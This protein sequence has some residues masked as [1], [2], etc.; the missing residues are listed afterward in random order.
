MCRPVLGPSTTMSLG[1]QE[2]TGPWHRRGCPGTHTQT[3]CVVQL[4]PSTATRTEFPQLRWDLP[5][6]NFHAPWV[7]P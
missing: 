7:Q 1:P 6:E 3:L 4:A 2:A 5:P